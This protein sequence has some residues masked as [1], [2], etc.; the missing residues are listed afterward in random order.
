MRPLYPSGVLL[1]EGANGAH[2]A[3]D[4]K[5]IEGVTLIEQQARADGRGE[6][7][8][9]E[10]PGNLPFAPKRIFC[11]KVDDWTA[12]RGGHAN[13]CDEFIVVLSGSVLVEVDNG[14]ESSRIRLEGYQRA[15]WV[16]AGVL[17]R[18]REFQA[19]T[20][21]MVCASA[22]YQDTERYREPRPAM[23]AADPST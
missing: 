18:L 1:Q 6:L 22:L 19:G 9:F 14:S 13:S 12:V 23:I 15:V 20:I 4:M 7:V 21:L 16:K 3:R 8:A 5:L 2:P 11:M 10:Q 17:V